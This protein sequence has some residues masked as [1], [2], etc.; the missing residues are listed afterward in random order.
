MAKKVFVIEW[1]DDLG[2]MWMNI[3]NLSSCLFSDEHIGGEAKDK[4]KVTEVPEVADT[5][6][7]A[8]FS[9]I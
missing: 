7:V 1:E 5:E 2:P 9:N 6:K 8:Y 4:V 3:F